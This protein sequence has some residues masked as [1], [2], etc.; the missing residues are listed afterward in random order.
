MY[1]KKNP[2]LSKTSCS[3]GSTTVVIFISK[4]QELLLLGG[5]EAYERASGVV[6]TIYQYTMPTHKWTKLEIKLP[7]SLYDFIVVITKDEKY[8]IIM[9][10]HDAWHKSNRIFMFDLDTMSFIESRTKLP[11]RGECKAVLMSND[12]ENDLLIHGFIRREKNTYN[13]IIPSELIHL[14]GIRYSNEWVHV[15][16]RSKGYHWK[17]NVDTLFEINDDKSFKSN[18]DKRNIDISFKM[19]I[20]TGRTTIYSRRQKQHMDKRIWCIFP[21]LNYVLQNIL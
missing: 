8:A 16:S 5:L 6:D 11:F 3:D 15:I 10:G 7:M 4:R 20:N 21:Y 19:N 2:L 9:G 12:E 14:I 18:V 13:M 1:K 17:L